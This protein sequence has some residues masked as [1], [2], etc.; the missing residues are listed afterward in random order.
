V[1]PSVVRRAL[2]AGRATELL[3]QRA[4]VRLLKDLEAGIAENRF[5]D[6]KLAEQV[7]ELEQLLL[8]LLE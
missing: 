8:P 1:K 3:G 2:R 5:L 7:D 6:A 4:D